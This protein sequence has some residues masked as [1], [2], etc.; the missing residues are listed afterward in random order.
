MSEYQD[1]LYGYEEDTTSG[2]PALSFGLNEK[3]R[4][5]KFEK[6]NETTETGENRVYLV[7]EFT[8][9]DGGTKNKRFYE[10]T[11]VTRDN[12]TITDR[13]DPAF[14]DEV[15]KQTATITH[16]VKRFVAEEDFKAMPRATSFSTYLDNLVELLNS[17]NPDYAEIECDL[18]SHYQWVIGK[19]TNRTWPEIPKNMKQGVFLTR[20]VEP[21]GKW[22]LVINEEASDS[23]V[24]LYYT[25]DAGNRHPITRSGWFIRSAFANQQVREEEEGTDYNAADTQGE[26]AESGESW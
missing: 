2:P 1:D 21:V 24:G 5:T 8:S 10:I 18:F 16:I 11:K 23:A 25:D 3:V 7:V 13:K 14:V 26:A 12:V 9:Q 15:K 20:H 4:L 6:V 17:K 22:H 19:G